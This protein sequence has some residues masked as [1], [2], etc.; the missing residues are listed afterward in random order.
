M[1]YRSKVDIVYDSLIEFIVGGK[2]SQGDRLVISHIA[3]NFGISETPVREAIRRL[4]SEGYVKINANSGAVIDCLDKQQV[5]SVFEIKGVLEGY[6]TRISIDYLSL[7]DIEEL[8]KIN[9]EMMNSK[10][11]SHKISE[12]NVAFHLKI[13]SVIPDKELYEMIENLWNKWKITKT[14]FNVSSVNLTE[15]VKE[16]EQIIKM[17]EDQEYDKVEMFVRQHKLRAGSNLI[18]SIIA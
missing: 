3:K 1:K 11:D 6:A 15:S 17:L 12:L 9:E 5:A 4:E 10:D 7:T 2:Y 14:V 16:H 13:Y 18:N 8:K